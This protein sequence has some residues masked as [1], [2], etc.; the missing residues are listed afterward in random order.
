MNTCTCQKVVVSAE[1]P[2]MATAAPPY[3][4]RLSCVA[5]SN[6]L[7]CTREKMNSFCPEMK[8]SNHSSV[9]PCSVV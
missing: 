8:R 1:L 3:S 6:H 2:W 5:F 7:R 4:F 9:A